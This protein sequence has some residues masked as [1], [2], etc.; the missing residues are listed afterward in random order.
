MS[1]KQI[2]IDIYSKPRCVACNV[3]RDA[4]ED[5]IEDTN[6]KHVTITER[7]ARQHLDY[8]TEQG[9]LAA[10]VYE[11]EIDGLTSYVSGQQPDVLVDILDGDDDI[12]DFA[13][14]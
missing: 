8:L 4:L 1:K 14:D 9:H 5:W 2:T 3:M 12:W 7:D 10:P 13:D 6:A 11:I